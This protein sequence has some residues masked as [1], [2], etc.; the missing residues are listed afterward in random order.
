VVNLLWPEV[1]KAAGFTNRHEICLDAKAKYFD[2]IISVIILRT[3][4]TKQQG[5]NPG[6]GW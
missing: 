2:H 1:V 3:S 6:L 4:K 5:F